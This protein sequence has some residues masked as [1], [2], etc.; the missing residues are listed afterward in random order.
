[1]TT[2]LFDRP[3]V[4]SDCTACHPR[5]VRPMPLPGYRRLTCARCQAPFDVLDV[6]REA[7]LPHYCSEACRVAPATSEVARATP[8]PAAECQRYVSA[9]AA[10]GGA[11]LGPCGRPAIAHLAN[12]E[13][14]CLEHAPRA[15]LV[16]RVR[17]LTLRL[18]QL[19]GRAR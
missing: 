1:M 2:P 5:A 16:Q 9:P 7:A 11:I 15:A 18:A 8:A 10:D 17:A 12:G 3:C 6:K 19:E 4:D 14:R 13:P